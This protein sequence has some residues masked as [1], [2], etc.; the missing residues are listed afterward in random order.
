MGLHASETRTRWKAGP[1]A[2]GWDGRGGSDVWIRGDGRIGGTALLRLN[3]IE[4]DIPL[5]ENGTYHHR[6]LQA[7]MNSLAQLSKHLLSIGRI[8]R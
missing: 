4:N 2:S 8:F 6:K 1:R 7:E 5:S 3:A